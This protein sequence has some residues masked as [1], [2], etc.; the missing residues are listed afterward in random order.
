[1]AN[2]DV[3]IHLL[4]ENSQLKKGLSESEQLFGQFSSTIKKGI[5]ALAAAFAVKFSFDALKQVIKM[6]SDLNDVYT[7]LDIVLEN[8]GHAAGFSKDQL[9]LMQREMADLTATSQGNIAALQ[10]QLLVFKNIRGDNF[11]STMMAAHDMAAVLKQDVSSS[12][13]TVGRALENPERGMM[14]LARS[15]IT[16]SDSQKQAVADMLAVNDVAGAQKVILDELGNRF[17]GAAEKMGGT[18]SGT[19]A[20]L[21]NRFDDV[22]EM[23][24]QKLIVAIQSFMPIAEGVLTFFENLIAWIVPSDRAIKVFAG[25]SMSMLGTMFNFIVETGVYAFTAVQHFIGNFSDYGRRALLRFAAGAVTA[26]EEIK[27][28]LTE[29]VPGVLDWFMNNWR[30]IF[31][32]IFNFTTTVFSNIGK[33]VM[34]FFIAIKDVLSGKGWTFE[35]TALTAGFES[36]LKELPQIAE[37]ELSGLEKSL[38]GQI[39]ELN[40]TLNEGFDEQYAKNLSKFKGMFERK[41]GNVAGEVSVSDLAVTQPQIIVEAPEAG[42]DSTTGLTTNTGAFKGSD[43]IGGFVGLTELG[44]K[45][46]ESAAQLEVQR[47]L[48][49]AVQA[50]ADAT[51]KQTE[52]IDQVILTLVNGFKDVVNSN[53]QLGLTV[54]KLNLGFIA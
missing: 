30:D 9:M 33:N 36:S 53:Q 31:T 28:F 42:S 39:S 6:G 48:F 3:V 19:L 49:D 50:T 26:F 44:S 20:K 18:F 40:Q 52:K 2:D 24:G 5:A 23:I 14:M 4:S 41:T 21:K 38:Y 17:G 27:Y 35:F 16:F 10:T 13:E 15:G 45:I 7:R 12:L 46:A 51:E 11:K 37:R 54:A 47:E 32:D 25:S 22:R 29:V 43:N 1:M 8:S 34:D